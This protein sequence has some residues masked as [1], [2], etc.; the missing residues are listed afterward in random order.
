MV[1]LKTGVTVEAGRIPDLRILKACGREF[2]RL[3]YKNN[4]TN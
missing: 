3:S 1:L 4:A 2:D